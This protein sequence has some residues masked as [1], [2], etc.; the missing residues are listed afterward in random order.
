MKTYKKVLLI[1]LIFFIFL[2]AIAL[3]INYYVLIKGKSGIL[4][5]EEDFE[6]AK[7]SDCII[8]LGAAIWGNGP[9]PVLQD[10][11]DVAIE[12]YK[13]GLAPKILM[14]GD[15][16]EEYYNEVKIMKN[17]AIEKGVPSSDIFMDHA[18][19]STYDTMF[20]AKEVFGVKKAIIITQ[21]YHLYRAVYNANA[22]GIEG[23]GF[24]SDLRTYIN[25]EL[26]EL[27]EILARNKDFLSCILKVKPKYLGD[28]IDIT[29]DGDV[30]NDSEMMDK[31]VKGSG[32]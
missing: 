7:G 6:K 16:G 1:M 18:G 25:A 14:S 31:H 23:Y 20:R 29:Q 26:R 4:V 27:R 24:N 17:Y 5:K 9:S 11:L 2:I 8:V 12:L 3:G 28:K 13:K 21:Q 15:H 19:F 10:R 32:N 30:T 22:L